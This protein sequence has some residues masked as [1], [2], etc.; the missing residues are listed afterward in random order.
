MGLAAG[1]ALA[2]YWFGYFAFIETT[3]GRSHATFRTAAVEPKQAALAWIG[4]QRAAKQRVRVVCR[5]YWNYWPLAYLAGND[6]QIAVLTWNQWRAR[7]ADAENAPSAGETWFVEFAGTMGEAETLAIL[8]A[9]G[10]QP[11]KYAIDD[12]GGRTVLLVIG[13]AEK[14]SQKY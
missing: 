4:Q 1:L 13:E 10:I 6:P 3:G 9:A 11:A 5:D 7:A 2:S 12:Y 14:S 8:S